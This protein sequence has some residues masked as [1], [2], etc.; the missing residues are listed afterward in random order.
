MSLKVLKIDSIPRIPDCPHR[1]YPLLQFLP[2]WFH[3]HL[4]KKDE[5][6]WGRVAAFLVLPLNIAQTFRAKGHS[7]K[8][9]LTVSARWWQ[10]WHCGSILTR[11]RWR[12]S[13]VG[14]QFE[15]ALH[16]NMRTF[17]GMLRDQIL[18]HIGRWSR[19]KECS[20]QDWLFSQSA[21]R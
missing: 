8:I 12:L 7:H 20:A 6:I 17:R 13:L 18:F 11:R 19:A 15:H 16:I 1:N 3:L 4:S 5:E 21:T 9:W 10:I 2:D 14:T